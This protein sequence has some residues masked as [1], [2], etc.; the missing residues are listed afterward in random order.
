LTPKLDLV[1]RSTQIFKG[2]IVEDANEVA[3]T[4]HPFTV[5]F[6]EGKSFTGQCGTVEIALPD[7]YS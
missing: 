6:N 2:S 3:S 7:E 1:I 4:I 5:Y